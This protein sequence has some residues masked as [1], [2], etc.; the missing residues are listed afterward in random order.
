[1]LEFAALGDIFRR[2]DM[3]RI[4]PSVRIAHRLCA[5]TAA[6][7]GNIIN[8]EWKEFDLE[9]DQPVWNI[10]H[11]KMKV[12]SRLIDHRIPLP[13]WKQTHRTRIY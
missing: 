10:P 1:M 5:F 13:H 6:R 11:T 9:S 8:A 7:I 2:A 3:A 4:S 12:K